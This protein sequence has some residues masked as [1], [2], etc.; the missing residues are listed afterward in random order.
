MKSARSILNLQL[1][2]HGCRVDIFISPKLY[3]RLLREMKQKRIAKYRGARVFVVY[4][5]GYATAQ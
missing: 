2:A 5:K 1:K 4:A 3:K